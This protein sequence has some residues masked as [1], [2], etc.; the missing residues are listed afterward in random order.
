MDTE[1][2]P[3]IAIEPYDESGDF[4]SIDQQMRIYC[5]LAVADYYILGDAHGYLRAVDQRGNLR[6]QYFL[7]STLTGMAMAD[8]GQTL[9]AA[10][11]TGI[12]HK[13]RL[14]RGQRDTHVIGTGQH[15][16]DFRLLFWKGEETPLFW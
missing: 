15:Y 13:L 3:G 16:E 6:W 1:K 9:W 12:I 11:C 5:G 2:F 7:G 8:D 4:V 14:G 10:S